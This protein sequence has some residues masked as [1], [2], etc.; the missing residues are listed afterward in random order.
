MFAA[1]TSWLE[2]NAEA[3]NSINV[4]PVPDGDT[5]T[6]MYLTMRATMD[7]AYESGSDAAGVVAKAMAK[8]A[9]MGARGNS[10]V[11]LSQALRGLANS[12]SDKDRFDG[13]DFAAALDEAALSAQRAVS[14]PVEGSILTVMREVAAAAGSRSRRPRAGPPSPSARSARGRE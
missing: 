14:Q 8:G 6:N 13:V 7:E 9:L 3:I 11:I 4:F 5:G 1:A 2:R 10:G 12:L